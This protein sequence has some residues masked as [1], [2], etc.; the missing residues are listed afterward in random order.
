MVFMRK[1]E[2]KKS[3]EGMFEMCLVNFSKNQVFENTNRSFYSGHDFI[4]F[5]D[6]SNLAY[7]LFFCT[8]F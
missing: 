4:L 6:A 8:M 2:G 7:Q 1:H 3:E 5:A